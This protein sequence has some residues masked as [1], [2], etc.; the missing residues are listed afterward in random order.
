MKK[1]G[2]IFM[3][4]AIFFILA[5][6]AIS[7]ERFPAKPDKEK[8]EQVRK[9]MDL[10]RNWRL[11][12]ELNLDESTAIKFFKSL[13]GIDDRERQLMDEGFDLI[14]K[15]R[16]A[17]DK[18]KVD[19]KEIQILLHKIKANMDAH[20]EL[21]KQRFDSVKSILTIE[22]QAKYMLFEM[23]FRKDM[24]GLAGKAMNMGPHPPRDEE[25]GRGPEFMPH[26][27]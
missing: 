27:P 21:K 26:R 15:L 23:N 25:P 8:M 3:T 6:P 17:T 2:I 4:S 9:K 11:M 7:V 16:D 19:E 14:D 1:I 10:L 13:K 22:Q 24:V 12:D 20:Y 18:E 5:I